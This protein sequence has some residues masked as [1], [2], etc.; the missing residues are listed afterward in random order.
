MRH[1]HT[2]ALTAQTNAQAS[3]YSVPPY[4]VGFVTTIITALF[5]DRLSIRGPV[6]MFW[7]AIAMIGYAVSITSTD[8][9]VLYGMSCA[10]APHC[11]C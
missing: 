7:M 2:I 4:A 10:L 8:R 11:A 5:S 6:I 3:L 1:R 9:H